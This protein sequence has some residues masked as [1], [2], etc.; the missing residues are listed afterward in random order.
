M[1]ASLK[2]VLLVTLLTLLACSKKQSGAPALSPQ[3]SLKSFHLSEDFHVELVAAE[4]QVFDPVEMAF[5]ENGRIY[6]AEML[7]YPDDPPPGKPARSRI[8]LLEDTDGDGKIDRSVIFADQVLEVSGLMP[9]KGGLIVTSAPDILFMKDTDGDGKADIRQ[10]LYTGFGKFN[11]EGRITNLRLGVDNWIYAANAG[12]DGL[13]TSP[14]HPEQPPIQVRGGDFRFHS[15]RGV[16]EQASGPTQ[17]GMAFDNWGNRFATQNTIH[18]RHVVLPMQYLRRAPLLDAGAVETDISDHGQPSAPVFPL[19]KPQA[20]REQRTQIRQQRYDENKL[21]R[22][23]EVGGYFTAASGG[24]SYDGDAFP[25]EYV[26]SI[27]TGDVNGN[28]VHR[29]I[30]TPDGVTFSAHRAKEGVEFLASTDA[31][32]RIC[33]FANAP[34]GN[35]Y[36]TDIYREFIETPES[37]PESIKKNMNFWSGDNLGRIYRFVPNHPRQT[38]GLKVNLGAA[39][40][41]ELVRTLGHANGW[42]R[43]TAQRLLIEKQDRAAVPALRDLAVKSENPL[44]RLHALWTLE[45]LGAL[46]AADVERALKD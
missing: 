19:T 33:N 30:L 22:K 5:D 38:R 8:R 23:E 25:P 41:D 35:L 29:D 4:P 13:I 21:D 16:A 1:T 36:M 20:W 27:F 42:H 43:R 37:I 2:P 15:I 45:G 44:A 46:E 9:W 32:S 3:D 31:W 28:L 26:G 24:T 39:S 17:F 12:H 11:P 18:L 34:D 40:I 6:V 14:A 7:D 10:V